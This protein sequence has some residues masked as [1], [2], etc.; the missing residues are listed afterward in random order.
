MRSQTLPRLREHGV[1]GLAE[2]RSGIRG[3]EGGFPV[4]APEGRLYFNLCGKFFAQLKD[5]NL[6][7]LSDESQG[8]K[9]VF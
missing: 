4:V 1:H 9:L 2:P 8:M 5:Q 3:W 7:V 6:R